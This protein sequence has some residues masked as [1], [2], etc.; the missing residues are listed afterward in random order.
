MFKLGTVLQQHRSRQMFPLRASVREQI[1]AHSY[2]MQSCAEC[3]A[4]KRTRPLF[5]S[6]LLASRGLYA[7]TI[8]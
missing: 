7:P 1:R 6:Q 5:P 4:Q 2:V 3:D 8:C